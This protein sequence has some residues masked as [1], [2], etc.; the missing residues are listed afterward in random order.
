MLMIQHFLIWQAFPPCLTNWKS[1]YVDLKSGG[2]RSL[3]GQCTSAVEINLDFIFYLGSRMRLKH[4]CMSFWNIS[5]NCIWTHQSHDEIGAQTLPT[6]SSL[7][8]ILDETRKAILESARATKAS[9]AT[10]Q[11][12]RQAITNEHDNE[13]LFHLLMD[14][15][16]SAD[17]TA[18][19]HIL[20]PSWIRMLQTA[21]HGTV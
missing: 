21:I 10:A 18:A 20:G 17:W 6:S 14:P 8:C 15:S 13:Q 1:L 12:E 11:K 4:I 7:S 16:S 5:F 19:L 9:V 3:D 2:R